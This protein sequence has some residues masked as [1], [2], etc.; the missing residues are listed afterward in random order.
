MF[1]KNH[2][3]LVPLALALSF[4]FSIPFAANAQ[5]S[6]PS[7]RDSLV[8]NLIQRNDDYIR[9]TYTTLPDSPTIADAIPSPQVLNDDP[10]QNDNFV[11]DSY[12]T[13]TYTVQDEI[14]L[15]ETADESGLRAVTVIQEIAPKSTGGSKEAHGNDKTISVKASSTIYYDTK[16]IDNVVY[17]RFHTVSGFYSLLDS[18]I[19]IADQNVK[20]AQSGISQNTFVKSNGPFERTP[21]SSSWTY[22]TGFTDYLFNNDASITGANYTLTLRRNGGSS[23]WEYTLHNHL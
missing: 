22:S 19:Q 7:Y 20:Y 5:Q 9:R 8:N 3:R 2:H 16:T 23:T 14:L 1:Q 21:K 15:S 4:I 10:L 11:D 12:T 17:Y 18:S 13:T 6:V